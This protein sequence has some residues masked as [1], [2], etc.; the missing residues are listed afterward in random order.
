[1]IEPIQL[2]AYGECYKVPYQYDREPVD[3]P[4]IRCRQRS[5]ILQYLVI[6]AVG[7]IDLSK[8]VAQEFGKE[9]YS[10]DWPFAS[11]EAPTVYL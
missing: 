5:K 6:N 4:I 9:T 10:T 2:I 3:Y 8:T 1:M 11:Q 7:R